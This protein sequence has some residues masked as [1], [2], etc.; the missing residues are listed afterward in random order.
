L[1]K[2]FKK[3][4]YMTEEKSFRNLKQVAIYLRGKGF[5]ISK[6]QIYEHGKARKIKPRDDGKY[7]LLDVEQYAA[8]FLKSKN[9]PAQLSDATQRRRNEAEAAKL[10]AQALHWQIKAKAA[11]GSLVPREAFE[12]ALS[13]RAMLFKSDLMN[14]AHAKAPE[15]CGL[16]N[17][18]VE[19]VPELIEYL[20]EQFAIF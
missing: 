6:T 13:Q 18:N 1:N 15:I 14:L 12:Q 11:E 17:G 19:Q 4:V 7:Y 8:E 20:L 5:K 10:E 2:N 3:G 16:V 9:T